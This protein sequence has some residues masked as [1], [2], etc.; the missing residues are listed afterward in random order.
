MGNRLLRRVAIPGTDLEIPYAVCGTMMFGK[1]ADEA[2][3]RR[4]V[5][6]ALDHGINL[7][8]TSSSYQWGAS[9]TSEERYGRILPKYRSEILIS[10]KME[11]RDVDQALKEFERSLKRL[12]TDYV[13]FLLIHSIEAS[14]DLAALEKGL[15]I[16]AWYDTLIIAPPLII[17]EE[18]VDQAMDILDK[19]LEIG[20]REAVSTGLP[21]S[22]SSQFNK[23]EKTTS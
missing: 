21:A 2:E 7:F 1:R 18:E 16:A 6:A 11:T 22:K 5:D 3:S 20:D 12:R 17:T 4:I 14:E 9:M 23:R 15:Y 19:S 13:D 10:T 8:D